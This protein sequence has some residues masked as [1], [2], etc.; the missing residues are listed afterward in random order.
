M[1]RGQQKVILTKETLPAVSKLSNDLYGYVMRYR[2]ISEDQNRFS[3]WSPVR[4]L[5]IPEPSQVAGAI[6]ISG[7]VIQAVWDD[8]EARPAY[9]VFVSFNESEYFYHGTTTNHQYSF[10]AEYD[11]I[12]V[13][14]AVQ[15]ESTNR[16]RS[17]FLTIFESENLNIADLPIGEPVEVLG[18]LVVNNGVAQVVWGDENQSPQYDIFIDENFS[19]VEKSLVSNKATISILG[20]H[21]LSVG[22]TVEITGDDNPTYILDNAFSPAFDNQILTIVYLDSS[23]IL[24]GGNFNTVGGVT[25]NSIAR[26]SSDG[27][28]DATFGPVISGSVSAIAVQPDGKIIIGGGI[29][30]VNGTTRNNIA[31]LNSDGTLDTGFNP[32]ANDIVQSIALQPDG[33]III[34]GFFTTIGG[35]TRNRIARLN[36]DGSLDSTFDPNAGLWVNSIAIQPNEKIVIGGAFTTIGGVTRNYIAR[37]NSDGTLDTGFDPNASSTVNTIA[38]QS[39]GKILIGGAF[40]AIGG[41][42]RGRIARLNSDGT[43]D[44][45]FGNPNAGGNVT[46]IAI[47]PD[48]RII[49]G[50][51]FTTIFGEFLRYVVL[52]NSDGSLYTHLNISPNSSVGA[53]AA[54]TDGKILFG[55]S[56]STVDGVARNRIARLMLDETLI[57]NGT[58]EITEVLNSSSF[59]YSLTDDDITFSPD[60]AYASGYYY[61][62]S[63]T[64]HQYLAAIDANAVSVRARVQIES[65]EN[66]ISDELTIFE[67]DPVDL[68]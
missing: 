1:A 32:N 27:T 21:S 47:R 19:I 25:R 39:D 17:S 45:G 64:T 30:T 63:S 52:I 34:G 33:K 4:E 37:L 43:L 11:A 29:S 41:V 24:V 51:A 15:I 36:I 44:T 42:S 6:A 60:N 31:R 61:S 8:E 3:H 59:S 2:I 18:F 40:A 48:G 49:V 10:I 5:S 58:H 13:Q 35:V 65:A 57:F 22:S 12:S 62:G 68:V 16:E 14:V 53:V 67:S 23:Q 38:I 46:S 26:L 56:F 9:D 20:N 66:E 28:L 7:S 54:Q 50:G 55:G